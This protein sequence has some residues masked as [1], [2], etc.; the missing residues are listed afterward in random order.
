[1]KWFVTKQTDATE[2]IRSISKHIVVELAGREKIRDE[3]TDLI[4]EGDLT[5]GLLLGG[6]LLD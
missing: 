2:E 3:L 5:V 6:A 4:R 1:M